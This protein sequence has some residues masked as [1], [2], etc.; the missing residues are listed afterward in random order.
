MD[1]QHDFIPSRFTWCFG[2]ERRLGQNV[3]CDTWCG[4]TPVYIPIN[5]D[6]NRQ[7]LQGQNNTPSVLEKNHSRE[8]ETY[9]STQTMKTIPLKRITSIYKPWKNGPFGKGSHYPRNWG[10]MITMVKKQLL[11]FPKD[12]WFPIPVGQHP[13]Q[14]RHTRIGWLPVTKIGLGEVRWEGW[15]SNGQTWW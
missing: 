9:L 4:T 10:P 8:M 15:W 2:C 12:G 7:Y 13:L 6:T 3:T 5:S 14:P 11:C 1:F